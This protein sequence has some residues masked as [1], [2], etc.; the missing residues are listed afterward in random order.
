MIF[1]RVSYHNYLFFGLGADRLIKEIQKA[2]DM[3]PKH[4]TEADLERLRKEKIQLRKEIAATSDE[5]PVYGTHSE[6]SFDESDLA[7]LEDI[8]QIRVRSADLINGIQIVYQSLKGEV[9]GGD[10]GEFETFDLED[11]E[12]ITIV[13]GTMV[14]DVKMLS[15]LTFSTCFGKEKTFGKPRG[16]QFIF[17]MTNGSYLG[18]I[19]GNGKNRGKAKPTPVYDGKT[20]MLLALGFI[21]KC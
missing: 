6:S 9:H 7:D 13:S 12:K 1:Y 14:R 8:N 17:E 4:L 15:S 5:S 2:L 21:P 20:N 18:A 16:E 3:K 10:G 19:K 11:D